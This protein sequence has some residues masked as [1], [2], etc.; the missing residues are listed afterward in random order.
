MKKLKFRVWDKNRK[1]FADQIN[2]FLFDKNG[3]INFI[4]YIDKTNKTKDILES[5]LESE[6]HYIKEFEIMQWTGLKDR[7]GKEVYVG[8]IVKG[9]FNADV[10]ES[11]IC[12][13]LTD[14]EKKEGCRY[15]LVENMLFGYEY[16]IP[17]EIE[18]VGNKYENPELLKKVYGL[19][20][21]Y[22]A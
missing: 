22:Q 6:K 17:N 2:R 5:E 3:N 15:F 9:Y 10:I 13:I 11:H 20:K 16:P 12:L 18:I 14:K 4:T 19:S 8:D 21:T 1:K 7:N